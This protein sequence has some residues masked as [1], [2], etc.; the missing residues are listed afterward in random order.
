[1]YIHCINIYIIYIFRYF[2]MIL[3][4]QPGNILVHASGQLKLG[5]FG[6]S[7]TFGDNPI[8][9]ASTGLLSCFV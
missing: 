6:I 3:M 7:R 4:L 9:D 5:D 1:M 8:V 2:I